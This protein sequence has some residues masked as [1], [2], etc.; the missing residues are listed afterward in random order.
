MFPSVLGNISL[1]QK[2]A[3]QTISGHS[4]NTFQKYY[5]KRSF[6]KVVDDATTVF[7]TIA[8]HTVDVAADMPTTV[9]QS[10]PGLNVGA[11]GT[12]HFQGEDP[13]RERAEW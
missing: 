7:P 1:R 9:R 13:N 12:A 8:K 6:R 3:V 4:E 11:I 2:N 10:S 5:N